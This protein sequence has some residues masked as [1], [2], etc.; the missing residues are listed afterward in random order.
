MAGSA[1]APHPHNMRLRVRYQIGN[2]PA[3]MPCLLR[4][5][6]PELRILNAAVQTRIVSVARI[7]FDFQKSARRFKGIICDDISEFE[8]YMPSHAVTSLWAIQMNGLK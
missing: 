1:T 2:S 4:G 5:T 8:S 7:R 6:R 3:N